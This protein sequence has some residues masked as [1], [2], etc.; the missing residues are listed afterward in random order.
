MNKKTAAIIFLNL[1]LAFH[2]KAQ[3][4]LH[5][6]APKISQ[7]RLK[8]T[9]LIQLPFFDDFANQTGAVNPALWENSGVYVNNTLAINPPTAG[10]ATFDA[11]DENGAVYSS[12]TYNNN[13][14]ADV[15]SSQA[16]DLGT[17]SPQNIYFSFYY[18]SQGIGNEPEK[19]D[20]LILQF[21][22]PLSMQWKKVW[23]SEGIPQNDFQYVILPI[24]QEEYLQAGFKF[25]F[26]NYCSY[27]AISTSSTLSDIDFWHID[28]IYLNSNRSIVDNTFKDISFLNISNSFVDKYSAVPWLHYIDKQITPASNFVIQVKN[29]DASGRK[30]KERII[31]WN[32]SQSGTS[33]I[34]NQLGAINIAANSV[35]DYN[36]TTP[37][38]FPDNNLDSAIFSIKAE[39]I[40]D[41][42]DEK[43]N[44][45][46]IHQQKFKDYYAY[47]DGSAEASYGILGEGAKNAMFAYQYVSYS[48][49]YLNAVDMYFTQPL[50]FTYSKPF[51][52]T[53]W[54]CKDGLP[55]RIIYQKEGVKPQFTGVINQYIR[56]SIDSTIVV[57][58]TI[59]IGWKQ[60]TANSL[61][62][63]YDLNTNSAQFAFYNI[64]GNWQSSALSGSVMMRPVI[65]DKVS[66]IEP[67]NREQ[68]AEAY[69]NPAKSTLYLKN[70]SEIE[71]IQLIDLSGRV[72]W[73]K[74]A[75]EF[76]INVEDLPYGLYIF[77]YF[78]QNSFIGQQKIIIQH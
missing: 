32:E 54:S 28:Y 5:Y 46:I 75:S 4:V 43:D 18:Q 25:R 36:F 49:G 33:S 77:K 71:R 11:Y 30:I 40:T 78:K 2:L 22:S 51:Y 39:I 12:A 31:S 52:L 26:L 69:P 23:F 37:F 38:T 57:E 6:A 74:Q 44:N 24:N 3:E 35:E 21:Y 14:I 61:N 45:Y 56:I 62:V 29:N 41:D 59:F 66:R 53:L 68:K 10:V 70:A 16:I 9:N 13:F 42:Y 15:L 65:T 20:S 72:I 67:I 73:T 76:P 47:D 8:T 64:D 27:N 7:T 48:S 63:G 60:T 19:E 17:N 34:L 50:S 58:D 1:F 55:D